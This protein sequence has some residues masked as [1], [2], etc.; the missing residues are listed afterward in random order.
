MVEAGV[1]A[2][3]REQLVVAAQLYD[4]AV[5]EH[6]DLVGIADG[7]DAVGDEQCGGG[8]SVVAQPAED[9][10]F[11]VGVHAGQCVVE[12]EDGWPAQQ[13]PGDGR[14]LFLSAGERNAA[15]AYHGLKALRELLELEADVGGFGGLH[16]VVRGGM[17]RADHQVFADGFAEEESLLGHHADVTAQRGE[18]IVAHGPVINE[19]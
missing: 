9:A 14:A 11:G 18:R 17:R 3:A 10:L 12:D 16:Q 4:S 15:L 2:I 5:I 7:G 13:C 19:Q 8:R 6:G 1:I